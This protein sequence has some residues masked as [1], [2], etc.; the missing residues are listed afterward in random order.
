MRDGVRVRVRVPA[1]I[2]HRGSRRR[3]DDVRGRVERGVR[4][5]PRFGLE[6]CAADGGRA[7]DAAG[8]KQGRDDDRARRQEV[9]LRAPLAV[10][11]RFGRGGE[12]GG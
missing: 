7:R 5:P 4:G 3:R 10:A 6:G 9:L 2:R 11:R 8:R 1:A 12:R